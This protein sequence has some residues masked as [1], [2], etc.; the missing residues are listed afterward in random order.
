MLRTR[1]LGEFVDE[2]MFGPLIVGVFCFY[3]QNDET[4]SSEWCQHEIQVA[5]D[6]AIP[7]FCLLDIDRSTAHFDSRV[8]VIH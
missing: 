8:C 3:S 7:I 4:M 5:R 2:G 1:S 6:L